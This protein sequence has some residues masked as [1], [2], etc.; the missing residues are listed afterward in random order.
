MNSTPNQNLHN[1]D[2]DLNSNGQVTPEVLLNHIRD[3]NQKSEPVPHDEILKRLL[4]Q[5][6]PI[7]FELL[8]FPESEKLRKRLAEIE[9]NC[10][11]AKDIYKKLD[12]FKINQRHYLVLSIENVIS[13][14]AK[15][16]WG[17]CKNLEFIYLYNDEFW[18]YIDKEVFQKFLGEAAELMGVPEFTAKHFQFREYLLKQF[19]ATAYLPSPEAPKDS[20][21]INLK[22]GTFEINPEFTGL[23]KFRKEDFLTYQLPFEHKK[24]AKA[25]IFQ[26][27]LDRV[28]PDKECQKVLAEFLGYVFIKNGGRLKLEK[29][30]ILFGT[31]ANGKSVFNEIVNALLGKENISPY[32]LESLTDTSG[33]NRAM[34]ATKLVNYATEINGKLETS[35][36]KQMVSGEPITARLPYGR[37]ME[38]KQYAK[39]IFNCNELPREVEHSNAYFRRFLIIPFTVTIPEN[40]QDKELHTKIISSELSGIFNW[41]LEGLNRLIKQNK[42][43]Q[44]NA[45]IMATENYKTQSDSVKQFLEDSGYA[46]SVKNTLLIKELYIEYRTFCNED[47]F[48]PVNKSNFIGRVKSYGIVIEKKNV[49]NVAFLEKVPT[50]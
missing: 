47:G 4:D 1:E 9:S 11:E 42:F 20:V 12:K 39:L 2:K 14:A 44:C 8:A 21:Y 35:L 6:Q 41:V 18:A 29:A 37:P 24:E 32:S 33:Y 38:L 3:L 22:N 25:P 27:Y 34:I 46:K 13:L 45:A 23:R 7:D 30:L 26:S 10:E 40:E 17:L 15:N 31:G 48:K 16:R 49:G 36:F 5:I 28:L 50:E 43:T 19:L